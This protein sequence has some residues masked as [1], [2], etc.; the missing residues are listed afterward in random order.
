[1]IETVID[2]KTIEAEGLVM[3]VLSDVPVERAVLSE[4]GDCEM[5]SFTGKALITDGVVNYWVRLA[6]LVTEGDGFK[7]RKRQA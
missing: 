4:K 6:A 5:V 1:M 7:R 3:D 2:T